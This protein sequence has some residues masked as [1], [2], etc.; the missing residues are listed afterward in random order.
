MGGGSRK[1]AW[2]C[3][4]TYGSITGLRKGP[5]D[6][7]LATTTYEAEVLKS[8]AECWHEDAPAEKACNLLAAAHP[9]VEKKKRMGANAGKLN[10]NK[11]V[12]SPNHGHRH[13]QPCD[14]AGPA[15]A[16]LGQVIQ[17]CT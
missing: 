2:A 5:A 3:P 11:T 1:V 7:T 4:G 17:A 12:K 13:E 15:D 6:S 16:L 14:R 9:G 10:Q 8:P